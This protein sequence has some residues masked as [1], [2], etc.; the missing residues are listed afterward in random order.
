MKRFLKYLFVAILLGSAFSLEALAQDTLKINFSEAISQA[1]AHNLDYQILVNNQEV[2]K[3]Q[4]TSAFASHFPSASISSSFIRQTGQQFQQIEG[5]IVVTKETN[6]IVSPGLSLNMPIFNAGRRIL[7]TQSAMLDRQAGE[8]GLQRARQQVVFD[9]ARRYM[10]VLLDQELLRIAEQNLSSQKELLLQ[11]EGFVDAG[12]RTLSDLYNQQAEVARIESIVLDA[13]LAL[14][15]DRWLLSEYLQL[16]KGKIPH[17][18]PVDFS[19]KVGIS[20]EVNLGYWTDQAFS[21]RK[22]L[23]QAELLEN[24]YK[25]DYQAV[26][27]MLYPRIN[28]F[29]NYG[30]F[31]TSLDSRAIKT[32]LLDIYPQNTFG[33]SLTIPIFN[34]FLT[35]VDMARSKMIY[36]NQ[37]LRREALDRKVH[38]EVIL[39]YQTYLNAVKKSENSK[40]RL[41]AA[42][43]AQKAVGE[44]FRLGLSNF[45]DLA[46]ANQALVNAEADLAQATY[47]LFFQ[48]VWVKYALGTLEVP[49]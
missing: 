23:L 43:E 42:Q 25:K 16:E 15:N 1:L 9:V 6:N 38:Q 17:L 14:A 29:Y 31:Y 24:S 32:Q 46:T 19:S 37:S 44:R 18:E 7:D 33:L 12:L 13:E 5:E 36:Q 10:Q 4:A 34:G 22:D 49:A 21:S 48:E 27:A 3:K 8:N 40:I 20:P 26:K 28:G 35:R 45:V 41:E 39:A 2:V 30:T 47:T 11:I